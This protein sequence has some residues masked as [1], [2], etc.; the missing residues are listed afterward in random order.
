MRHTATSRMESTIMDQLPSQSRLCISG[1]DVSELRREDDQVGQPMSLNATPKE[2]KE[3][4]KQDPTL[5]NIRKMAESPARSGT[6][7]V[8]FQYIGGL[9][10]RLG[11]LGRDQ[12][13]K[14][15]VHPVQ[16]HKLVLHLAHNNPLTGHHSISKT[17]NCVL[18]H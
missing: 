5:V 15:L 8:C 14:Q 1:N 18:Q 11:L 9:L 17:K 12:M 2:L 3:W 13:S 7:R 6:R 16:C 10:Y 4:Q